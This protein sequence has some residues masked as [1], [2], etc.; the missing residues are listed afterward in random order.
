MWPI[1]NIS[2]VA[3]AS[4]SSLNIYTT[5]WSVFITKWQTNFNLYLWI[6]GSSQRL[7]TIKL[8]ELRCVHLYFFPLS[9]SFG[10]IALFMCRMYHDSVQPIHFVCILCYISGFYENVCDLITYVCYS[11][12]W[13]NTIAHTNLH[14]QYW[15]KNENNSFLRLTFQW[16]IDSSLGI[17][18]ST[19]TSTLAFYSNECWHLACTQFINGY[20]AFFPLL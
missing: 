6:C 3:V 9:R 1:E 2:I 16:Q 15:Y 10:S 13:S 4:N 14:L 11:T 7:F 17:S 5:K 19:A 18:E 12:N 20:R 8:F